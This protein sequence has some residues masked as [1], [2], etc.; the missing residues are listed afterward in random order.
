MGNHTYSHLHSFRT[1]TEEYVADVNRCDRFVKT[2][3]FRPPHACITFSS[4]MKLKDN[5][6]FY[7]WSVNSGDSDLGHFDIDK[8]HS[9]LYKTQAGD[10]ILF[11]FCN[12]HER[13]TRLLLPDYC[14]W[15]RD[16]GYISLPL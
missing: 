1:R 5:Y 9:H 11:H 7:Y 16:N 14:K 6:R 13:E 2:T 4:W 3:L 12:R 8:S 10:I 15:L